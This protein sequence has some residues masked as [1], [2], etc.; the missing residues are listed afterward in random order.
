MDM[1]HCTHH[2][3]E[4]NAAG[5]IGDPAWPHG[6]NESG[7]GGFGDQGKGRDR[8]REGEERSERDSGKN[9]KGD[10]GRDRAD[11]TGDPG[12][13]L[14][15]PGG[16]GWNCHPDASRDGSR[17]TRSDGLKSSARFGWTQGIQAFFSNWVDFIWWG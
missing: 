12:G 9:D 6:A 1:I 11:W 2:C 10:M 5:S 16:I 13:S 3:R 14:S 7:P 4:T 17:W 15:G 8:E